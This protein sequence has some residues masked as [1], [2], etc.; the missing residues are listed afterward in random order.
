VALVPNPFHPQRALSLAAVALSAGLIVALYD[1]QLALAQAAD[2]FMDVFTATVL[3][4][5]VAVASRPSDHDHPFGHARAEPIGALIAA[6]VAGV[7]AV[8]VARNAIGALADGVHPKTDWLLATALAG[9]AVIKAGVMG[10]ATRLGRRAPSPAMDALRIDARND[11]L[12]CLV[13]IVGFFGMRHGWHTLDAIIA[14]P[15]AAWIAASGVR[16]A[17]DNIRLLM[18]EAPPEGRQAELTANAG[19]VPGVLRAHQIRAHFVG[20]LLHVHVI[21]VVDPALSVRKAH[22]IGEAVRLR[23]EAEVDVGHCSVHIDIE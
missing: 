8:E 23:L 7:L 15:V 21:I 12:V 5:T 1:S 6:L 16:L 2:S 13:S 18:G 19:A 9:K 14:L 4:W 11:V 10:F 3:A 20:T 17:R 22:D